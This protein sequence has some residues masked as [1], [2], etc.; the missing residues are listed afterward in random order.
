MATPDTTTTGQAPTAATAAR[1][2][3]GAGAPKRT[4][5][6]STTAKRTAS[7]GA[8]RRTTAA[9]RAS[10]P[11]RAA[12]AARSAGPVERVVLIPVGAALI[13]RERVL[14]GVNET[15]STY[16]SS[17]KLSDQLRLFERRGSTARQRLERE[18]RKRRVRLEREVRHTRGRIERELDRRRRDSKQVASKVQ[19]R[20]QSM[21]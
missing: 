17:A 8:A 11:K 12:S 18:V 3:A 1:P 4:A 16:A 20:L 19:E 14:D 5:P 7:A 10:A 9:K 2:K 6:K 13:A 15:I 21:V